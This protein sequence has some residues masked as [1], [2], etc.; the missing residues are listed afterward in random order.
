MWRILRDG[1]IAVALDATVRLFFPSLA[2]LLPFIWVAILVWLTFD[3]LHSK[4][5]KR[6]VERWQ[7][8][9]ASWNPMAMYLALFCIG[10]TLLC[11]YWWTVKAALVKAESFTTGAHP[12]PTPETVVSENHGPYPWIHFQL[13]YGASGTSPEPGKTII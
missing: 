1:L 9:L 6:R 5:L 11:I 3:I 2:P 12:S 13:S 4:L 7:S 8:R 10:G